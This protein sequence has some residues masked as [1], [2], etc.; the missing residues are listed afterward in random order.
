L[1]IRRAKIA[2]NSLFSQHFSRFLRAKFQ[3]SVIFKLEY[4]FEYNN[5][6]R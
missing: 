3:W 4:S 1:R 5:L 2:K 6:L